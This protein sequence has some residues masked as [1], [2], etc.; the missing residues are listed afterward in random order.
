MEL[1]NYKIY[2]IISPMT[3]I[4]LNRRRCAT[5][6]SLVSARFANRVSNRAIGLA[7]GGVLTILGAAMI[8]LNYWTK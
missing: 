8:V 7:T 3:E 5:I 1:K 4:T 6:S 2:V